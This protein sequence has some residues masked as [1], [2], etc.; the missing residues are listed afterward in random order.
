MGISLYEIKD[1]KLRAA[2]DAAI[3]RSGYT[4]PKRNECRTLVGEAPHKKGMVD[5]PGPLLVRITRI[6]AS[7][8]ELYDRQNL[9][10]GAK[11][12]QDAVAA[13]LSRRSDSEKDGMRF[14]Y[15]QEYGSE[16]EI[17]IEIF[18]D[19]ELQRQSTR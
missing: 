2:I 19:D 5:I 9:V 17:R 18:A 4:K 16:T 14:E 12:I 7:N 3:V 6:V 11:Q 1:K 10:G 8:S 13:F 15:S